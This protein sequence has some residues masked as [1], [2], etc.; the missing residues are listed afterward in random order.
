[1]SVNSYD[2]LRARQ[3]KEVDDFPMAFAF[4]DKQFA[5][6]MRK[7][8]LD[9]SETCQVLSIGAG[10]FIRKTDEDA[11]IKMFHRHH[12][13]H[14]AAIA[15]DKTGNGYIYEMFRYELANHEYGYTRNAEP[16]LAALG[17]TWEQLAQ[18]Q[19]VLRSFKKACKDEANWH[20][21]H[22]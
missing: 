6:G 19:R 21:K 9:P 3:Q 22:R 2:Q 14:E 15:A 5:E 11:F 20:D 10:G 13:E 1:M 17:V 8:G 16:A 4:N 12:T 7:L 18:D